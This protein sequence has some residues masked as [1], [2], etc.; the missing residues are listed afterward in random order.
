[1]DQRRDLRAVDLQRNAAAEAAADH[2]PE[3]DAIA[4][5]GLLA[6]LSQPG[7]AVEP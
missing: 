4:L 5:A 3:F 6:A 7:V 2:V 1:M